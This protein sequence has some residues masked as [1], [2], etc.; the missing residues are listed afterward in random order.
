MD[1]ALVEDAENDVNDEDG[2]HQQHAEALQ[3]GLKGL[4]RALQAGVERGWQAHFV[5][6]G[7][8][9]IDRAAERETG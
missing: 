1:E 6:N 8:D 9:R 7:L 2:N 3:R 4:C 5:F